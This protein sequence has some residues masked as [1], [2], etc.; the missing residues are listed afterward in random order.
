MLL[1]CGSFISGADIRWLERDYDFGLFKEIAGPKT[2]RSRFVNT[3]RDTLAIVDVKPSCGCT[4]ADF[5]K[6]P[7]APGD[8]AFVS[9]TYDPAMRPGRFDKSVRVTLSD[10]SRHVLRIR[11]NV[12]GTPESLATLYTV[13]AVDMRLSDGLISF[14]EVTRGRKPVAFVNAY[15]L[16]QDSIVPLLE[17]DSNAVVAESSLAKAGPGDVVTF[18]VTLDSRKAPQYGPA[19]YRLHYPGKND[20]AG[21]QVEVRSEIIP[22]R[23]QLAIHQQGKNPSARISAKILDFSSRASGDP[24]PMEFEI[25]NEGKGDLEIFSIYAENGAIKIGSYPAKIKKGK[26]ARVGVAVDMNELPAG[27]RRFAL[28]ILTNDPVK[29]V[30]NLEI[31]TNK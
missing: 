6:T 7:L 23:E 15:V 31:V 22:D 29:P 20:V 25:V 21:A 16:S 18:T 12:L 24:V 10:G 13:D 30:Q 19:R 5:T 1:L 14:G 27:P 2:G 3:G 8:T 4:S 11:G 28:K 26:S 17:S 9:Y